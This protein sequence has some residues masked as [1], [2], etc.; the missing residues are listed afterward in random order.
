M[1]K[2][3]DLGSS[4]LATVVGGQHTTNAEFLKSARAC[5][6]LPI[7]DLDARVKCYDNA[8]GKRWEK[9]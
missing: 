8:A 6:E 3:I 4:S 2:L 9:S 1:N 7:T 5:W